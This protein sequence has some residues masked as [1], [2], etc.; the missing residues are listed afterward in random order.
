M[1]WIAITT[2]EA[3]VIVGLLVLLGVIFNSYKS[4]VSA[5]NSK[6]AN[7]AVNH[8]DKGG[9]PRLYDMVLENH[10][11][12]KDLTVWKDETT[13]QLST[14]KDRIETIEV[15]CPQC[16]IVETLTSDVSQLKKKVGMT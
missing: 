5:K 15:N 12:S 4:T 10:A 2:P 16:A 14:I 1:N 13:E 9:T 8:A 11:I 3:Q 7:D 6:E